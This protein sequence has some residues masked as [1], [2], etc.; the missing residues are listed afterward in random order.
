MNPRLLVALALCV[1][2]D[3]QACGGFFC[4][5]AQPVEILQAGEEVIFAQ[6]G[7]VTSM[8]VKVAFAG[9]PTE[10]GWILPLSEHPLG[11]DGKPLP[12]DSV[13]QLSHTALF[14]RFE[15]RTRPTFNAQVTPES[16][17]C[18]SAV[19]ESSGFGCAQ[20]NS[21]TAASTSS[22]ESAVWLTGHQLTMRL[23][24]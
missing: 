21:P 14:N 22:S 20:Q 6:H 19:S 10:F 12:L 7:T 9:D 15:S 16:E 17:S 4:N 18:F 11:D 3:A 2:T 13:L 24:R 23:P 8:H 1:T 5:A